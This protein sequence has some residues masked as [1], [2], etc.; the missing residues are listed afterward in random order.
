MNLAVASGVAS[1]GYMLSR[2]DVNRPL[3]IKIN[4]RSSNNL[5]KKT[6]RGGDNRGTNHP[7]TTMMN[8][9]GLQNAYESNQIALAKETEENLITNQ[10]KNMEFY[11][12]SQIVPP[13]ANRNVFSTTKEKKIKSLSGQV[14]DSSQF[15]H[16]NMVPFFG[17]S[18]KQNVESHSTQGILENFTG[19]RPVNFI[20]KKS[21]GS[22]FKPEQNLAY[23]TGKPVYSSEINSRFNP[24]SFRQGEFP[25]EPAL[26]G[27]GLGQG[28]T[29]EPVGG[30]QQDIREYTLPKTVDELRQGSN[31]K[32]TYKGRLNPSKKIGKRGLNAKVNKNKPDTYYKN[33]PSRYMTSVTNPAERHRSKI[34]DKKTNRQSTTKEYTGSAGPNQQ[35]KADMRKQKYAPVLK[36]NY[37]STGLRNVAPS[38]TKQESDYGKSGITIEDNNRNT[39]QSS[40]VSSLTT[41]VKEM[42]A[43]LEDLLKFSKKENFINHPRTDGNV[44]FPVNKVTVYDPSSIAKTTIKETNIHDSEIMNLKGPVKLTVYDPNAVAKTTIRETSEINNHYG[45]LGGDVNNK[46]VPVWN[47]DDVT[48]TTL[49]EQ[50]I[51]DNR[52]GQV[53]TMTKSQQ[54]VLPC[55]HAKITVKETVL[56][57]PENYIR[58]VQDANPNKPLE[59]DPED[60]IPKT[61]IKHDTM[62]EDYK[63]ISANNKDLG[64]LTNPKE[65]VN[66]QRQFTSE[67]QYHG[68]SDGPN[69]GGYQ[70]SEMEAVN[71]QRQFTSDVPAFG[72]AVASDG[73]VKPM[74]YADIYNAEISAL[75]E[76]TLKRHAPTPSGK[77]EFIGSK[78]INMKTSNQKDTIVINTRPLISTKTN[79]PLM[80]DVNRNM[81][82]KEKTKVAL[83]HNN[84]TDGG[85]GERESGARLEPEL[86][87]AY[88]K[89]P[90]TQSLHSTN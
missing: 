25:F 64:Y 2:N 9:H 30:F 79:T 88:R 57:N 51:H 37:G 49:K 58:N 74:S 59:Y 66:T 47:P 18:I 86:L 65:A 17:G 12:N 48:R 4:E 1:L 32:I 36:R 81:L 11:P 89:N 29:T 56:E 75:K 84:K 38:G 73:Q 46:K 87:D 70:V 8:N 34:I 28:Y 71:T 80:I 41:V 54:I 6:N 83:L 63:G 27:P 20:E 5:Q 85:F 82:T 68:I 3:D 26:V 76:S 10:F 72:N 52:L 43:P 31:P 16:N 23:T 60:Y 7:D 45:N 69:T 62:T 78:D 24:S 21:Q 53:D 77:K 55:D 50:N 39:T 61:T 15:T 33:D 67:T 13:F 90:Y 44:K 22:L 35:K 14:M 40:Y 19:S 42:I